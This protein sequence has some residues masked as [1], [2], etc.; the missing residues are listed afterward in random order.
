MSDQKAKVQK[1]LQSF[2]FAANELFSF[3]EDAIVAAARGATGA[4]TEKKPQGSKVQQLPSLAVPKRKGF[5][6]T[7]KERFSMRKARTAVTS[8]LQE[9]P[10][11]EL[12]SCKNYIFPH[13]N[14]LFCGMVKLI[15]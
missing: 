2:R 12:S 8:S 15:R 7:F 5:F 1:I 4:A 13:C 10:S 14:S 9:L 11:Q 3:D 6:A